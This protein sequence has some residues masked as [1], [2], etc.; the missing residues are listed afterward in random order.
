M[1]VEADKPELGQNGDAPW[2]RTQMQASVRQHGP[3]QGFERKEGM[4][5]IV[6]FVFYGNILER[7]LRRV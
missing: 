7:T 6:N 4:A 5:N 3:A 2:A 1:T